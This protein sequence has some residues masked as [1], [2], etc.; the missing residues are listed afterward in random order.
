MP[1]ETRIVSL[2]GR[3]LAFSRLLGNDEFVVLVNTSNQP[4]ERNVQVDVAA[5]QLA[6]LEAEQDVIPQPL[7]S[8]VAEAVVDRLTPHP[9]PFSRRPP[10]D[11]EKGT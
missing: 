3:L 9:C 7:A 10:A 8:P 4:I 11:R 6:G 2:T 1:D 5:G